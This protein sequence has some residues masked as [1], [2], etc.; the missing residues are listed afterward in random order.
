MAIVGR[1]LSRL[2][3]RGNPFRASR[4]RA[5]PPSAEVADLSQVGGAGIGDLAVLAVVPDLLGWIESG[6][7]PGRHW[8][9]TWACCSSSQRRARPL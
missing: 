7:Q 1:Q 6:A 5:Q 2:P 9:C 8:I 3:E 4:H